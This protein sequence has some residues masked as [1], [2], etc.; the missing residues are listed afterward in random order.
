MSGQESLQCSTKASS[1]YTSAHPGRKASFFF[2]LKSEEQISP[3]CP[4][5]LCF[6]QLLH[7]PFF[8]FILSAWNKTIHLLLLPH[9]AKQGPGHSTQ[10]SVFPILSQRCQY[11]LLQFVLTVTLVTVHSCACDYP[12]WL[13]RWSVKSSS[14]HLN[15]CGCGVRGVGRL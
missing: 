3:F 11:L 10:A 4:F 12:C 13:P 6:F 8:S 7:C 14:S 1:A 2:P 5:L 15:S 9:I